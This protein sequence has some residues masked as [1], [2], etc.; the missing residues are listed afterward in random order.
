MQIIIKTLTGKEKPMNFELDNIVIQV[1][2]ALQEKEGISVEQF[3]LIFERRQLNDE[4]RLS[5]YNLTAGAVIHMILQLS[6]YN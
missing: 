3:R 4:S 6:K 5:D 1:K 2:Q